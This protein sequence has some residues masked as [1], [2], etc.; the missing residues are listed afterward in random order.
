MRRHAVQSRTVA[1]FVI[2]RWDLDP[3]PGDQAPA[4][5]HFGSQEA[6]CVLSGQLDVRYGAET[7]RLIEGEHLVIPA[8]IVHTFATVGDQPARILVV[9]SPEV[10]ALIAALHAA[11]SP[12]ERDAAWARHNSALA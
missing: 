7:R 4:H 3:Y 12:E 11:T 5:V 6:F 1:D 9:M 2:E 8:G 10:Q